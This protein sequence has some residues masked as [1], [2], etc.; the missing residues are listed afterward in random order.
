VVAVAVG[1]RGGRRE[2]VV[3]VVVRVTVR[4]VNGMVAVAV[5]GCCLCLL[6]TTT[7]AISNAHCV[8]NARGW[9]THTHPI[10]TKTPTK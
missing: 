5:H 2:G 1:G 3:G 10:P 8:G 7:A 9:A 4:D 6:L